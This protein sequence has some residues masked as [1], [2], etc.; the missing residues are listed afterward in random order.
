[1]L[2][3]VKCCHE[4]W[5]GV[6]SGDSRALVSAIECRTLLFHAKPGWLGC[7]LMMVGS[8]RTWES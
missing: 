4:S 8:L 7:D 3:D 1:M 2:G 5:E 6:W